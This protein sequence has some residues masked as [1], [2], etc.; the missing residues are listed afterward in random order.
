[1]LNELTE[2]EEYTKSEKLLGNKPRLTTLNLANND[3]AGVKRAEEIIAR[4]FFFSENMPFEE[5]MDKVNCTKQA[6]FAW[7]GFEY[8]KDCEYCKECK[9]K[10][11]IEGIDAMLPL[12]ILRINN[13]ENAKEIID[14]LRSGREFLYVNKKENADLKKKVNSGSNKNVF[15]TLVKQYKPKKF[16]NPDFPNLKSEVKGEYSEI[17]TADRVVANAIARGELKNRVLVWN[18]EEKKKLKV[19][20]NNYDKII[21][22]TAAYLLNL[23]DAQEYSFVN[24]KEVENW[25]SEGKF[26]ETK[27]VSKYF[28][29][30]SPMDFG[31]LVRIKPKGIIFENIRQGEIYLADEGQ[32]IDRSKYTVFEDMGKANICEIEES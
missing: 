18:T 3:L 12:R 24:K 16:F 8:C 17:I 30:Y 26:D 5:R 6:L 10:N 32:E 1:M 2:Y 19:R 21:K 25:F 22:L 11:E 15:S 7:N 20:K 14:D 29:T 13:V 9:L 4:H 31:N 28:E 27:D 23:L